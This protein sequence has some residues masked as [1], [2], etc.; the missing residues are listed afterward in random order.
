MN[1]QPNL[2]YKK[3]RRVLLR[4]ALNGDDAD[5][6]GYCLRRATSKAAGDLVLF[7]STEHSPEKQAELVIRWFLR[8]ERLSKRYPQRPQEPLD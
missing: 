1:I 4:K 5:R 6:M 2:L 3:I 8:L 7:G